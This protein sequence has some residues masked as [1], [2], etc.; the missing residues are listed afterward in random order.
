MWTRTAGE[1][2]FITEDVDVSYH[3]DDAAGIG[4]MS[5]IEPVALKWSVDFEMRNWGIKGVYVSIPD[6]DIELHH[7]ADNA[8]G[9]PEDKVT[10]VHVTNAQ[11][12]ISGADWGQQL[13]PQ[14]MDFYQGKWSVTF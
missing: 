4:R 7:S 10:V 14:S 11:A 9:D 3:G 6:Q 2:E 1:H 13:S 5:M 12:D 8:E